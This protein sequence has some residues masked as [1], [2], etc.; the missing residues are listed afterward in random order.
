[1]F[2]IQSSSSSSSIQNNSSNTNDAVIRFINSGN[3]LVEIGK[4]FKE[5]IA[6]EYTYNEEHV[7][8]PLK[9]SLSIE[10]VVDYLVQKAPDKTELERQDRLKSEVLKIARNAFINDLDYTLSELIDITSI[11]SFMGYYSSDEKKDRGAELEI[12]EDKI[13]VTIQEKLLEKMKTANSV[14]L[15]SSVW[16]LFYLRKWKETEIKKNL[17]ISFSRIIYPYVGRLKA[18]EISLV[19]IGLRDSSH[20]PSDTNPLKSYKSEI[21]SLLRFK[22]ILIKSFTANEAVNIL[23][24]F[25]YDG[26]KNASKSPAVVFQENGKVVD[27]FRLKIISNIADLSPGQISRICWT[28]KNM[29]LRSYD[30]YR[31]AELQIL[32]NLENCSIQNLITSTRSLCSLAKSDE[33]VTKCLNHIISKLCIDSSIKKEWLVS[34]C[35]AVL[36]RLCVCV[37]NSTY[38]EN[39]ICYENFIH[40]VL[41]HI[42]EKEDSEVL[43]NFDLLK[44]TTIITIYK[45][46][47]KKVD[48]TLL[49]LLETF[50]PQS[51]LPVQPQSSEFHLE[52]EGYMTKLF[53]SENLQSEYLFESNF[54]LDI[55]YPEKRIAV[56]IDGP[57]HFDETSNVISSDIIKETLLEIRGWRL[58]RLSHKEWPKREDLR[59]K[60]L[61]AKMK[62]FF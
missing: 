10:N 20:Y 38:R 60:V 40:T 51:E 61:L 44:L 25:C 2:N 7:Y 41:K 18:L 33:T 48:Q 46:K 34:L 43:T 42:V 19:A 17:F 22:S 45:E 57:S 37:R 53:P 23:H 8:T 31:D 5:V 32:T 62:T 14:D 35:Y 36:I 1:M 59:L 52:V 26:R 9:E 28:F 47:G 12:G 15:D 55:A 30:F 58:V 24:A 3:N 27:A 6:H 39:F 29:N 50:L 11:L 56:E 49:N 4:R 16:G 54:F 21:L 13:S